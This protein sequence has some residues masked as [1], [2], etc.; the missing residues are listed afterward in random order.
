MENQRM[1]A[2]AKKAADHRLIDVSTQEIVDV[3][4]AVP[5]P[6]SVAPIP[7]PTRKEKFTVL[8]SPTRQQGR[9]RRQYGNQRQAP[10]RHC[11]AQQREDGR[12][13]QEGLPPTGSGC[14]HVKLSPARL[15]SSRQQAGAVP[16]DP[17]PRCCLN[18]ALALPAAAQST[19]Q[20]PRLTGRMRPAGTG[21]RM[22]AATR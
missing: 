16:H 5:A 22:D 18:T 21:S 14:G 11:R 6:R 13:A 3:Q 7:L 10:A 17:R 4:H 19:H 12:C 9:A 2:F 15:K 20:P 8:I 1:N